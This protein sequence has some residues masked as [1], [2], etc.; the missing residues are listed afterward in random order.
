VTARSSADVKPSR[1]TTLGSTLRRRIVHSRSLTNDTPQASAVYL[2][3]YCPTS[4]LHSKYCERGKWQCHQRRASR[5]TLNSFCQL[6][7]LVSSLV[8]SAVWIASAVDCT[9]PSE[10][11]ARAADR[12]RRARPAPLTASQAAGVHPM[13]VLDKSL[14][15]VDDQASIETLRGSSKL[16]EDHD[17]MTF[18]LRRDVL[19]RDLAH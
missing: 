16:G 11:S 18:C 2:L 19:V 10:A 14:T 5:L 6:V 1:G 13:P 8:V 9:S 17:A 3:T 4:I 7:C 15:W 12:E